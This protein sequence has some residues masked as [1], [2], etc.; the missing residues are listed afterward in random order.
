MAP[1][2]RAT[3]GAAWTPAW[4]TWRRSRISC[5]S[6]VKDRVAARSEEIKAGKY[7]VFTGPA[8]APGRRRGGGRG[9]GR[10]ASDGLLSMKWFVEGVAGTIPQ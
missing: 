3:S 5:P 7:V 9:P 8:E 4:C 1:G 10:P 2:P 6:Q